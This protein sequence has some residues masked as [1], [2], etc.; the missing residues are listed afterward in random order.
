MMNWLGLLCG[1]LVTQFAWGQRIFNGTGGPIK[2]DKSANVYS[3]KISGLAT[4]INRSFGLEKICLNI[5][6][7]WDAD[8]DIYL[9]SPDGTVA[10][11]CRRNGEGDN[12]FLNTCLTQDAEVSI[13]DGAAP[14]SGNYLPEVAFGG[15]NNGQ[16]PNGTW[17]LVIVDT[18]PEEES[19]KVNSWS[20]HFSDN[21][22]KPYVMKPSKL[23]IL[24]I[25]S[26]G[27]P[28]RDEPKVTVRMGIID[29]G[30]GKTNLP[31]DAWNGFDGFAKMEVRGR[32]SQRHSK[33]SFAL[34][35]MDSLG[36]KPKAAKLL[37]LPKEN[38]FIL[39]AN[40]SD[41]SLIRNYLA[42]YLFGQMGHYSPRMR[43]V[44]VVMDGEYRGVYLLGEK[45]KRGNNRVD[46]SKMDEDDNAGDSLTGG[47]IIKTDWRQGNNNDGWE[48]QF[49]PMN[50]DENQ[51][52]LFHY[53]EA[54]DITEQQ[55]TYIQ[56][57]VD[58]FELACNKGLTDPKNGYPHFIDVQSF[59]DVMIMS[60]LGKNVDAYWLSSFYHKDKASKGGKLTAGPIWDYDLAF[61]NFEYYYG[62][63]PN[64]WH[65]EEYGVSSD[66]TPFFW[67]FLA[68]DPAFQ[69]QLK[70]RWMEL[71]KNQLS[72]ERVLGL[73]DS[74]ATV[75]DGE[76]Q[77]NFEV[78]PILGDYIWPNAKPYERD[79]EGEIRR[80]KEWMIMRMAWMDYAMPG[81]CN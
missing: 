23:P 43:F 19:G 35:T 42:Y 14:F 20:L 76:Q 71:R 9:V 72:Q 4:S 78:W 31:T 17:K 81:K 79:Y 57:F 15:I 60:E 25:K 58:S 36:Q 27:D 7:T 68:K 73:I 10:D 8:L 34:Q 33:L 69:N 74:L 52:W 13:N 46:V 12:N 16:N 44:S 32:S 67:G 62:Y 22:A 24:M 21:P 29:N 45:I 11:L 48:S 56:A 26:Q 39:S 65:W 47:Y 55:R 66:K 59:V 50:S 6:H 28:V 30:P 77:M 64:G 63:A 41:K 40:H 2:D 54:D 70:C 38:D 75:M 37:D 3:L 1:V 80:L 61:G 51:N 53:P 18:E 49:T 5:Q